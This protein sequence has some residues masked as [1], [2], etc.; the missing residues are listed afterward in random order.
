MRRLSL[1]ALMLVLTAACG[2]SA[3]A[4]TTDGPR[5]FVVV[6]A[7]TIAP[8][9]ALQAATTATDGTVGPVRLDAF[10]VLAHLTL[11]SEH[12]GAPAYDR[13]TWDHWL[14]EDGDGCDTRR[15][16]L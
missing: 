3:A 6:A 12:L 11:A 15:E 1:S 7:T 5:P 10:D 16:V 2:T 14:D 9:E 13:D 8:V 4:D